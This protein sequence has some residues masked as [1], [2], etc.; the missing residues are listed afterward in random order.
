M[1]HDLYLMSANPS[2]EAETR[3][4]FK[5]RALTFTEMAA[6]CKRENSCASGAKQRQLRAKGLLI[7][8][9]EGV[10]RA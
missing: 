7:A 5:H 6:A 3:R 2:L 9:L 1:L 10:L 4:I 8:M